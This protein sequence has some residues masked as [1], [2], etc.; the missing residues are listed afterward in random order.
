MGGDNIPEPVL[1]PPWQRCSVPPTQPL[2]FRP[3]PRPEMIQTQRP[4][5]AEIFY[6]N[7][8][9]ARI[10]FVAGPFP[11]CSSGKWE[12]SLDYHLAWVTGSG[13]G[14]PRA[15]ESSLPCL[16]I[17][18]NGSEFMSTRLGQGAQIHAVKVFGGIVALKS[19]DFG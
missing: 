15:W 11:T 4:G 8:P 9:T 18:G 16:P 1:P 12:P 17:T 13:R 19:V 2:V 14:I 3:K 7:A 5:L 6:G 10:Y